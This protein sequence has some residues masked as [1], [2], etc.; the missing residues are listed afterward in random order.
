MF[1]P[2]NKNGMDS[3]RSAGHED[4][5]IGRQLPRLAHQAKDKGQ[6]D[7]VES[8]KNVLS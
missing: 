3:I 4:E 6:D 2:E 5:N 1:E 8:G 7:N